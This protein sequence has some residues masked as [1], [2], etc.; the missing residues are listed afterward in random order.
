MAD[1]I[2]P[3]NDDH[4]D[5]V[6][7]RAALSVVISSVDGEI[8][9]DSALPV[10]DQLSAL[11]ERAKQ[12]LSMDSRGKAYLYGTLAAVMAFEARNRDNP[13]FI[14]TALEQA[15]LK[16]AKEGAR[17][18]EKLAP[19]IKLVLG[20]TGVDGNGKPTYGN[21]IYA[22]SRAL[23]QLGKAGTRRA[24]EVVE[25][26]GEPGAG[27]VK[28]AKEYGDSL[29]KKEP[30]AYDP[31]AALRG[32]EIDLGIAEGVQLPEG[33]VGAVVLL[34]LREAGGPLVVKRVIDKAD[35]V[36]RVVKAH[37]GSTTR[38]APVSPGGGGAAG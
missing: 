31:A 18:D 19:I 16:P 17:P 5:P 20:S 13:D 6:P 22:Y 10:E 9:R 25:K 1:S 14:K 32:L 28:L 33:F 26:L 23:A 4:G 21:Q 36:S 29:P 12:T 24:S 38:R 2:I 34:V 27:V 8:E 35:D 3:E 7:A 11:R 30:K 37:L 15:G